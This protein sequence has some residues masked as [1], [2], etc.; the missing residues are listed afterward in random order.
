MSSLHTTSI[1]KILT[2]FDLPKPAT[3]KCSIEAPHHNYQDLQDVFCA[4]LQQTWGQ[5]VFAKKAEK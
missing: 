4:W 5:L 3:K 1:R 2:I